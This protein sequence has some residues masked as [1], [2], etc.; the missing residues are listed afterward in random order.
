[1]TDTQAYEAIGDAWQFN[2]VK[3]ILGWQYAN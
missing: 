1:V 2:A 3:L